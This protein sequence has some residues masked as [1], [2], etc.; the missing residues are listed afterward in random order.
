MRAAF[1]SMFPTVH[2]CTHLL[3]TEGQQ[4]RWLT[5]SQNGTRLR[6]PSS[7]VLKRFSV[8]YG[9]GRN[10]LEVTIDFCGT[11]EQQKYTSQ[12]MILTGMTYPMSHI[13]WLRK[14]LPE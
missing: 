12:Q 8:E 4:K 6:I 14:I 2:N 11:L 1:L 10:I 3:I 9:V 13:C 7:A 5:F